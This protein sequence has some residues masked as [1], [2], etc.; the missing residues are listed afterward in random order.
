MRNALYSGPATKWLKD[1]AEGE[2]FRSA[3]GQSLD[4]KKM[5]DREAINRFCAFKILGWRAYKTG[6]MDGFLAEGLLRLATLT[7]Q[8]NNSLRLGFDHAMRL[9]R[10]LFGEHAFRKSLANDDPS[11]NRSIVN[12]SL[13]EICAVTLSYIPESVDDPT[14][15]RLRAELI[16]AIKDDFPFVRAITYS[17]NSTR[18]VKKRF[19]RMEALVSKAVSG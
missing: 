14:L 7:D 3:T 8:E 15:F 16:E 4:A 17:T 1:A 6:D 18:S 9:N 2:A 11:S 13:F 19:S 12:I 5:R 10:R